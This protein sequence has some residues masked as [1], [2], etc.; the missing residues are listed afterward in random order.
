MKREKK[1]RW[2]QI[3][4]STV[5]Y[6]FIG[7]AVFLTGTGGRRRCRTICKKWNGRD[8]SVDRCMYDRVWFS[9][10]SVGAAGMGNGI[11]FAGWRCTEYGI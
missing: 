8:L 3:G 10:F 1:A 4:K 11:E 6:G 2:K 9:S 7:I 5:L